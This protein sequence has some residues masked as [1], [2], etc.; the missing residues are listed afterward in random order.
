MKVVEITLIPAHQIIPAPAPAIHVPLGG[1]TTIANVVLPECNGNQT[2][3]GK[4]F[5]R[6][7]ER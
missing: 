1:I 6:L 4:I 7:A 5:E 3:L 2:S